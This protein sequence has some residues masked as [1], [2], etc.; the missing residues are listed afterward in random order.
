MLFLL[1]ILIVPSALIVIMH[2]TMYAGLYIA[3]HNEKILLTPSRQSHL[4]VTVLVPARDE[5]RLLPR[6]LHSLELQSVQDFSIILVNDRSQDGTQRV[7]SEYAQKTDK[8]TKIVHLTSPPLL[9]NPKLNALV[10]GIK[11]AATDLI[12]FTDADCVVPTTWIETIRAAFVKED[13]GIL[14]GPIE[15]RKTGSFLSTFHAFDHIFKFS[16]TA[17]CTGINMP[18]GGF[19]NNLAIRTTTLDEIGGLG[20]IKV[21]STEDAALI[22]AVRQQSSWLVRALYSR[23]ML[24]ITEPQK[25]WRALTQQEVRWHTGGL[26]SPDVNTKLAYGALMLYLLLSILLVPVAFF[27][28]PVGILPIVS[29]LT[30]SCMAVICGFFTRQ[31]FR[32][33]WLVLFPFIVFSMIYNSLLTFLAL[34]KPKL[35][36]KGDKLDNM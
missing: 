18:T 13:L 8:R 3:R 23:K 32:T 30:M 11:E 10:E 22:A 21:T 1:P 26:F 4:S 6:L 33:Y 29:F 17:G 20:S 5:E 24:V 36:W 28:P 2:A 35:I 9:A 31:P 12:L 14:L 16:Y 15:T 19:G 25:T 34:L 7:M 27:V